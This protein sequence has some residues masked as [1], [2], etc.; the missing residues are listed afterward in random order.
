MPAQVQDLFDKPQRE[1]T[2]ILRARL[3]QC[4]A[5]SLV[6]GFVTVEGI[7]SIAPPFRAD[8]AKLT[9]IVVGLRCL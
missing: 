8:P 2:S 1:I 6:S 7:E 3:D 4:K 9:Q 5:A